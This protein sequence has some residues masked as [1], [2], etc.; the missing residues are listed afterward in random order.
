ARQRRQGRFCDRP[1]ALPTIAIGAPRLAR[2]HT[3]KTSSGSKRAAP[4]RRRAEHVSTWQGR[5]A[6]ARVK[7]ASDSFIYQ[8]EHLTFNME[9][10]AYNYCERGAPTVHFGGR[11]SA[12]QN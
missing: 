1:A 6:Q 10:S 11:L 12:G 3:C 4:A 5:A 2:P 9:S 8:M 7:T